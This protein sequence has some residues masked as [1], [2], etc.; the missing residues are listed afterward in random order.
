MSNP[1]A[2]VARMDPEDVEH[3]DA[4]SGARPPDSVPAILTSS[5]RW[6]LPNGVAYALAAA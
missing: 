3:A 2:A 5:R 1:T 6:T 4:G